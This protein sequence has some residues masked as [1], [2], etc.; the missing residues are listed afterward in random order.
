LKLSYLLASA[1]AASA[2]I[3]AAARA[4]AGFTATDVTGANH[5]WYAT[6]TTSNT[7]TIA[8]GDT[9]T[10]AYPSGTSIHNVA[11]NTAAKPTT[12][13][14]ALGAT[15]A[16]PTPAARAPWTASCRF[17]TP[18]TYAF[19]CQVHATMRATIVVEPALEVTGT[20][21]A[22]L[23]LT[24]G[25]SASLGQF[26][27]AVARDYTATLP[28]TVTSTAADATLTVQDPGSVAPGHLVNG[29]YV[30]PQPLQVSAGG[31]FTPIEAPAILRTWP[32]PASGE[33]VPIAFKQPVAVTD[34]L[35]SGSYAKTLM[36]TLSTTNP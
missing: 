18:G 22:T 28:A 12:C 1:L 16:T 19:V 6:G 9:V 27:L 21:P 33:S 23:A 36:F 14:P 17:D 29:T 13:T 4:D 2:L 11:F 30:M 25:P 10:F 26:E 8:Q 20:V 31:A 7:A 5:Q 3:P 35:R 24:L 34:A 15:S 32:G